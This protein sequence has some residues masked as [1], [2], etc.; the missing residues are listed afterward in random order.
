[1]KFSCNLT[2]IKRGRGITSGLLASA[3]KLINK[4]PI[5]SVV[6]SVID[7]LPVELH[8]PGGYQYC[9]PGTDL[10]TRLSRGDTGINKLD[11][12]CK[13][14]D[15]TYY[16]HKDTKNRTVADSILANKAWERVKST[17]A[18]L[19]ERAAALAVAATMKGKTIVGGGKRRKGKRKSTKK[20]GR[21]STKRNSRGKKRTSVYQMVK[22]GKGLY[23][24]PYRNVY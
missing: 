16:K 9:G 13:D 11:K 4:I 12:A 23:L 5:G 21:G 18:S 7:A 14:H 22:K 24:K 8:L 19:A 17:D 2:S 20:R 3:S 1:M 6:N 15:I 10:K